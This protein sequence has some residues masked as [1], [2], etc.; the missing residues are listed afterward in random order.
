M[1]N[2]CR[3][4]FSLS[5]LFLPDPSTAAIQSGGASGDNGV[6]VQ[7]EMKLEPPVPPITSYGGGVAVEKNVIKR[8]IVNYANKTYFGYDL[9]AEDAGDGRYRLRFAPLTITPEFM[10]RT[11]KG[12][13][14]WSS[15][16]LPTQPVTHTIRAGETIALDLF[17]N[18][19]T[20]Q[21][22]IDYLRV[23][24]NSRQPVT[25]EGAARDFS[26][27]DAEIEL[28]DPAIS[29]DGKRFGK[30]SRGGISGPAVW[31]DLDGHGRF[32][33]S[34]APRPDLGLRRAGEIRGT[35]MTWRSGSSTYVIETDKPIASGSAAYHLYVFHDPSF[36]PPGHENLDRGWIGMSAGPKP[37]AAFRRK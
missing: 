20:G 2:A 15:L 31:I 33:F 21:K 30:S 13:S 23:E 12:T 37:D 32:V 1:N 22:L 3:V 19:S 10:S 25:V 24:N 18:P 27:A 11:Y 8:H 7:Y 26:P 14:G 6:Y 28:S 9:T 34:L 36:R 29:I 4:G 17:V 16:A 5:L 35:T